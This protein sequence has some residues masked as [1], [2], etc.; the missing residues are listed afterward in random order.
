VGVFRVA[1]THPVLV[2]LTVEKEVSLSRGVTV[3]IVS[4]PKT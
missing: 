1:P 3:P 2:V 4:G